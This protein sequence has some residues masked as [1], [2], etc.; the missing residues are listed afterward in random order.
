LNTVVYL[1]YGSNPKEYQLELT[2]SVLSLARYKHGPRIVLLTTKA[3]ARHDLPVE[4]IFVEQSEVDHWMGEHRYIHRVKVLA[5]L[6]A[7]DVFGGKVAY[8]D[9]D[10]YF[11]AHPDEIFA[12]IGVGRTVMHDYDHPASIG[13]HKYWAPIL[14][15]LP[16]KWKGYEV[17][18]DSAM[19]NAGVLGAHISLRPTLDEVIPFIDFLYDDRVFNVEQFVFS[20]VFLQNSTVSMCADVI[21]HYWGHERPFIHLRMRS[22]FTEYTKEAFEKHLQSG[23]EPFAGYPAKSWQDRV[24]ARARAWLRGAG[25]NYRWA[26]LAYLSA[27]RTAKKDPELADAWASV[28]LDALKQVENLPS[29]FAVDFAEF[30]P[31]Q[32]HDMPWLRPNTRDLWCRYWTRFQ[33]QQLSANA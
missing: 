4:H 18:P 24:N 32:L 19:N 14:E 20:Q 25:A 7:L 30:N 13:Q 9:T 15:K 31:A 29:G 5:L 33:A 27:L 3:N 12:R 22:K 28:S 26:N 8:V 11:T 10:T 1:I 16:L 21:R 23:F 6:R 2:Y 17:T